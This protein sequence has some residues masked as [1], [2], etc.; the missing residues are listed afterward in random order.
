MQALQ[1]LCF[2]YFFFVPIKPESDNKFQGC[3]RWLRRYNKYILYVLTII[4]YIVVPIA[5]IAHLGV[6]VTLSLT[7]K[8]YDDLIERTIW[9][10]F[11]TYPLVSVMTLIYYG[12]VISPN[13]VTF[14]KDAY[15]SHNS[16]TIW[17]NRIDDL[18][19]ENF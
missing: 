1:F 9:P 7:G 15:F 8:Y 13:I 14:F 18:H 10:W 6:I 19:N 12:Y 4:Y 3:Q 2:L 16:N 17:E 11:A 5:S